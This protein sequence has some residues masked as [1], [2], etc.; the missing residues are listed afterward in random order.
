[1]GTDAQKAWYLPRLARG[2]EIPCFAL[3]APNAG[4]DAVQLRIQGIICHGANLKEK[5]IT[6]FASILRSVILHWQPVATVV[7][8]LWRLSDPENIL[9]KG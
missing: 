3:T 8:W 6:A 7:G 4:S 9:E 1:M 2:E 5:K